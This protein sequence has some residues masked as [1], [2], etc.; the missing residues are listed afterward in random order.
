[1]ANTAIH[2]LERMETVKLTTRAK[3]ERDSC[4]KELLNILEEPA[5]H[6]GSLSE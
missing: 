5:K 3:R 2:R 1:V 6:T 4:K